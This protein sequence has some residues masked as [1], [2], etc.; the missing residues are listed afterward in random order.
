MKNLFYIN[1]VLISLLYACN[2]KQEQLLCKTWQ[3][4]DVQF[5]E[6][7][8]AL[9]QSDTLQGNQLEVSKR[10]IRE[11]LLKNIYQFNDDGT[12]ITGNAVAESEGKWEL[13]NKAIRFT[14]GTGEKKKD[15]KIPLEKLTE[16]SLIFTMEKDQTTLPVRLILTPITVAND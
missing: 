6:E 10:N 12:F 13:S 1:L 4:S 15:K 16:D 9:V 8:K 3:V 2:S 7:E 14:I 11:I 5:L